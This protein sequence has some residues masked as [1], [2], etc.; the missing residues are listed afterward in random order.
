M[1]YMRVDLHNKEN[2]MKYYATK[3][4]QLDQYVEV[5]KVL[6]LSKKHLVMFGIVK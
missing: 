1:G 4:H 3:L 5:S 6:V 2:D